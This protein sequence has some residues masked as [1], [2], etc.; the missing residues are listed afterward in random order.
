MQ[1]IVEKMT[2]R[3][4]SN[5]GITTMKAHPATAIMPN[6]T[7][8][9]YADL[10]ADMSV[11]G[12][13]ETIKTWEGQ[14]VDGRQ[15]YRACMELGITPRFDA[16]KKVEGTVEQL[17]L[18][19]N[20]HRRH[21]TTSQ[22]AM[23]AATTATTTVGANQA[24]TGETTQ[25]EA[26]KACKVSPDSLQRAKQVLAFGNASLVQAVKD[27]RVDVSNAAKIARGTENQSLD[28]TTM[29]GA[30]LIQLAHCTMK[31]RGEVK[32]AEKMAKVEALRKSSVPLPTGGKFD[33]I[34]ADPPWDYMDEAKLGYPTMPLG[35]ICAMPV[36]KLAEDN[37]VLLLWVPPSLLPEGLA[38][39]KAWG[40]EFKASAV[41]DKERPGLGQ[42]FGNQHEHILLATRGEPS[43]VPKTAR[44]SSVLREARP[45][46]HSRKP[47]SAY[48]MIEGM[49]EGLT[50]LELFARGTMRE[51]WEGWGNQCQTDQ[52][53]TA[54]TPE[55]LPK[56]ATAK[57]AS[58]KAAAANDAR[59][60]RA[61]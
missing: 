54:A 48:A 56:A 26:A 47:Q 12:Q 1:S 31:R 4:A 42:Y 51:G 27:G 36:A 10:K 50:K 20:Y 49:Y 44:H 5:K 21:L 17:V 59:V 24:S 38:V 28:A 34:Y 61:A 16:L 7:D 13:R 33:L 22:K 45:T 9:E 29:S 52:P 35:E 18:S 19:L 23:I 11:H 40:F 25:G 6:M 37:A 15:R 57:A 32:H 3:K 39:I 30:G 55:K 46:Q 53:A 2:S 8:S 14:I 41:W 60:K 43:R 58:K